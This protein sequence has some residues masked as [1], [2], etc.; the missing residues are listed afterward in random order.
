MGEDYHLIGQESEC[1]SG[2]SP[3]V[4]DDRWGTS[5]KWWRSN[6]LAV[7]MLFLLS[8]IAGIETFRILTRSTSLECPISVP[9]S[10]ERSK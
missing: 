2:S 5:G 4:N 1:G 10:Q 3:A 9:K 6:M 7:T 8:Y